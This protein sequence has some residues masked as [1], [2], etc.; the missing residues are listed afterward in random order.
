MFKQ[1]IEILDCQKKS[2]ENQK[3]YRN[4]F[5]HQ[6]NLTTLDKYELNDVILRKPTDLDRRF[7]KYHLS[8]NGKKVLEILINNSLI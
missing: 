6:L 4:R 2:V 7:L 5:I 3:Q 8:K 1:V